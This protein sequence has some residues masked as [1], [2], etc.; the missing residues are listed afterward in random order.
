[1]AGYS[2]SRGRQQ[3][4]SESRS[5][6]EGEAQARGFAGVSAGRRDRTR[7]AARGQPLCLGGSG[8]WGSSPVIWYLALGDGAGG[9]WAWSVRVS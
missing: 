7:E 9:T 8:L 6:T 3:V 4:W 5:R 2:G 1:M